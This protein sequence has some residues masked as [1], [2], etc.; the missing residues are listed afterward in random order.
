MRECGFLELALDRTPIAGLGGRGFT[1]QRHHAVESSIACIAA[2]FEDEIL[3]GFGHGKRGKV[4][5]EEEDAAAG[6]TGG[7]VITFRLELDEGELIAGDARITAAFQ[8]GFIV[9]RAIIG[10]T[11]GSAGGIDEGV[12]G[13]VAADLSFWS[14]E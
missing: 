13:R 9:N 10:I 5:I 2:G 11:S 6:G 7:T 12:V 8:F 3:I 1:I 4:G 14:K